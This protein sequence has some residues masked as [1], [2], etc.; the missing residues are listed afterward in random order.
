[1]APEMLQGRNYGKAADFWSVGILIFD[2]LF[3]RVYR[4]LFLPDENA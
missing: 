1:M 4:L 3:G 2:M